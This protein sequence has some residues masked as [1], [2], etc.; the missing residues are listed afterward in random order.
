MG[1]KGRGPSTKDDKPP[2]DNS[3]SEGNS[4]YGIDRF[5]AMLTQEELRYVDQQFKEEKDL[6]PLEKW[7]YPVLSAMTL[8]QLKSWNTI[9]FETQ[10]KRPR[11]MAKKKGQEPPSFPPNPFTQKFIKKLAAG[12]RDQEAPESSTPALTQPLES[13]VA[14]GKKR[15]VAKSSGSAHEP[16]TR[17]RSAITHP[18][19]GAESHFEDWHPDQL[20]D[21]DEELAQVGWSRLDIEGSSQ[22]TRSGQLFGGKAPKPAEDEGVQNLVPKIP[23]DICGNAWVS[24]ELLREPNR[25]KI[26][27]SAAVTGSNYGL[28][29][30]FFYIKHIERPTWPTIWWEDISVAELCQLEGKHLSRLKAQAEFHIPTYLKAL[31]DHGVTGVVRT[32]NPFDKLNVARARRLISS[33]DP[34]NPLTPPMMT[35]RVIRGGFSYSRTVFIRPDTL[36][37]VNIEY[38]RLVTVEDTRGLQEDVRESRAQLTRSTWRPVMKALCDRHQLE[39]EELSDWITYNAYKAANIEKYLRSR[40]GKQEIL[41]LQRQ[42]QSYREHCLMELPKACLLKG[43][44]DYHHEDFVNN[45]APGTAVTR[46]KEKSAAG[47]KSTVEQPPEGEASDRKYRSILP[48]PV[49]EQGKRAREQTPS[50]PSD[51]NSPRSITERPKKN[52]AKK[53]KDDNQEKS[54]KGPKKPPAKK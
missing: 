19:F 13:S 52:P 28:P 29:N 26:R 32:E 16:V 33:L 5:R 10:I 46:A 53:T 44:E 42:C 39:R 12:L 14:S 1:P 48:K 18:L 41:E 7:T 50:T 8:E 9:Y 54:S 35:D 37:E 38:W 25:Y 40:K 20:I 30:D 36:E 15:A 3:E 24:P 17:E 4:P 22:H 49:E 47:A 21:I 6:L 34:G 45:W 23:Q 27:V 2:G 51:T 11:E 43:S 31:K